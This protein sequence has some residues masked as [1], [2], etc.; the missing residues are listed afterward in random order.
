MED[1]QSF[2]DL[3]VDDQ[4]AINLHETSKWAKFLA[5]AILSAMGL[6]TLLFVAFWSSM[7]SAFQ[8]TDDFDE[9][10]AN[11]LKIVVAVCLIIVLAIVVILMMFLLK[12]A[13]AIRQAVK[14]KDPV[15]FNTG[16]GH[17]RNYFAM[18]GIL[19]LLGLVFKIMTFF[20]Q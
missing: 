4:A 3:Q 11:M 13:N 20:L 14:H 1:N 17:I 7:S 15:L 10:N 9:R 18:A 2:L 8:S 6:V 12:G 19:S 16:L 5:V